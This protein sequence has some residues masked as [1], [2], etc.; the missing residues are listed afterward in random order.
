MDISKTAWFKEEADHAYKLAMEYRYIDK[1]R[2]ILI[3]YAARLEKFRGTNTAKMILK[4]A[5]Q[6]AKYKAY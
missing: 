3:N 6:K 2:D 5:N 4:K 1:G